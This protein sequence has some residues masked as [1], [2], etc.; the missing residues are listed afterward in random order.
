ML[1]ATR[2]GGSPSQFAKHRHCK[3]SKMFRNFLC[4]GVGPSS[5]YASFAILWLKDNIVRLNAGVED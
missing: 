3:I 1:T 4:C 2:N 5:D